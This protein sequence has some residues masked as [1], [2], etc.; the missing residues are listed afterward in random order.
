MVP[1][2]I[3]TEDDP[4]LHQHGGEELDDLTRTEGTE[5]KGEIDVLQSGVQRSG[6]GHCLQ[7]PTPRL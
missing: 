2:V 4:P 5:E 6:E 1:E 7:L 3:G